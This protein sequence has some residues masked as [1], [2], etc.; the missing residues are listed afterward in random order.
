MRLVDAH[1]HLEPKDYADVAVV[2]ERARAAGL[3]HA[4]LV[5]QFE[6]PGDWGNALEIAARHPDFL[7]PTLGIHPHAAARA[8]EADF[9]E[10]ERTCARPELRAVGEAGLDYYYDHSP[11]DVQATVFRRQCALAK[12]LGKPLVV[13]VRDAHEDC[14]AALAAEDVTHGVIHCFTGDTD[15]A[16]R[17]LDRGFYLSLSGV[18]TYKKT[19][20]LQD[21]VRF[22]PLE[23]L[24]VETDSPYLAPVPHRGRK[25]EPAHVLETAKKMAELK[26]VPLEE[27]AAVTTANAARLFNLTLR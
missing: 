14:D 20:A 18:I 10:L 17:Y 12:R 5:G 4:V 8:T 25:N 27:V 3:V 19:E 2:L 22:A 13:H 9:E 26:G 7:S 23:R 24:M 1:C 11:R 6:N 21:A 15:A 16:R